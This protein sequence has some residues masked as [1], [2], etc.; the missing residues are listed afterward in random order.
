MLDIARLST[1]HGV[2]ARDNLVDRVARVG[3]TMQKE[4]AKAADKSSRITGTRGVGT[5]IWIDT[6]AGESGN[7]RAHLAAK[8]VLVRANGN[9][10]VMTKPSLTLEEHHGSALASALAG[11]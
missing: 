7:L 6:I 8:G 9:A 5:S 10:G 2:M 4:V 11:F 1:I 3:A